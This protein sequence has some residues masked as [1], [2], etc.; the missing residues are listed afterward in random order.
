MVRLE[1]KGTLEMEV[2]LEGKCT[3]TNDW[4]VVGKFESVCV[5]DD[6][7]RYLSK[8]HG[9]PYRAI[10]RRWPDDPCSPVIMTFVDGEDV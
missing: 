1:T 4:V 3:A 6:T 5:A 9:T 2:Y 7:A 10:D 8:L